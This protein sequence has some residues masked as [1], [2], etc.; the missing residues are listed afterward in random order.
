MCILIKPDRYI[1]LWWEEES[2]GFW[3]SKVK[4]T[5]NKYEN[6]FMNIIEIKPLSPFW[7]NVVQL[8]RMIEGFQC[9]TFKS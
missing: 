1:Y 5:M 2:S 8:L 4:V 9:Q 7:L 6:N 3:R